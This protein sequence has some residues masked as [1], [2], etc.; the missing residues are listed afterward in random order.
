VVRGDSPNDLWREANP[1]K[2]KPALE[3]RALFG[4]EAPEILLYRN[5]KFPKNSSPSQAET[6]ISAIGGVC[7]DFHASRREQ[8]PGYETGAPRQQKAQ[9]A[10]PSSPAG[11]IDLVCVYSNAQ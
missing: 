11:V 9:E 10:R 1:T 3:G 7:P 8:S 5:T 4:D 6:T 2:A